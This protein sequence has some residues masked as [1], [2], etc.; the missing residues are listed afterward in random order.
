MSYNIMISVSDEIRKRI[1]LYNLRHSYSKLQISKICSEAIDK[2]L[3]DDEAIFGYPVVDTSPNKRVCGFCN[4]EFE[5][6]G[7]NA[8][9]C[10]N[11]CRVAA[12]RERK[13]TSDFQ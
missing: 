12:C 1:D 2:V 7:R 13:K 8:V 3:C 6:K 9:Y 4:S 10:S 11:K 5:G